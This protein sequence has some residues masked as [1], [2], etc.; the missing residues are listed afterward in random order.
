MS[1]HTSK[2]CLIGDFSV[3]KTSL[4]QRYVT[5]QFDES[6]LT[7]VGVK[8]DT[9]FIDDHDNKL[10]IW[11]IAGSSTMDSIKRSYIQGSS[12]YL[13]IYDL[14]RPS[15]LEAAM[16]LH[17]HCQAELGAVPFVLIG[18]KTDLS[19]ALD[20]NDLATHTH[21]IEASCSHI[22]TSALTGEGVEQAFMQLSASI[23]ESRI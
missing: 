7:T 13:L 4:V 10:I 15:T 22:Q 18:N 20:K 14:S 12:G 1:A 19:I 8:I 23:V 3:G 5:N 11:D 16:E 21:V 6:Y 2:I 9:K 17:G